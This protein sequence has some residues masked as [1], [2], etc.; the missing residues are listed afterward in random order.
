[1]SFKGFS[2]NSSLLK[3]SISSKKLLQDNDSNT[4]VKKHMGR[5]VFLSTEVRHFKLQIKWFGC[6][7]ILVPTSTRNN[8]F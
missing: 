3:N 8:A 1:M 7:I 4:H 2:T 5:S 6:S